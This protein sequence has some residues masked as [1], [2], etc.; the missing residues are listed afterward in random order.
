M[1]ATLGYLAAQIRQNTAS[2]R[3]STLQQMSEASAG[4]HDL[5]ATNADLARIFF[6]GTQELEALTTEERLRFQFVM[7]G[8]LRRVENFRRQEVQSRVSPDEWTGL[9]ASCMSVMSQPGSLGWWAENVQRFDSD[10]AEWLSSELAE[11]AV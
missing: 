2:V 7:L 4:F 3:A 1:I 11:R 6:A 10:F 5:L 8:F 9:R